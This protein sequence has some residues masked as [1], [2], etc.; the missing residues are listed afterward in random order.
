M[1]LKK[2]A[3][4]QRVI[5]FQYT[6]ATDGGAV[7]SINTGIFIPAKTIMAVV[8]A[9]G[10]DATGPGAGKKSSVQLTQNG[11]DLLGSPINY[12]AGDLAAGVLAVNDLYNGFLAPSDGTE[13]II[14]IGTGVIGPDPMTDGNILFS[15]ECWLPRT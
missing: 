14:I 6:P 5:S 7:G 15:I 3:T 10:L 11:V 9:V 12:P 1:A 8:S 13:L 4:D 2:I